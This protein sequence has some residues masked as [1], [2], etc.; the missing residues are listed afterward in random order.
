[1]KPYD[2]DTPKA[3]TRLLQLRD[4]HRPRSGL[5]DPTIGAPDPKKKRKRKRGPV[6]EEAE[7]VDGNAGVANEDGSGEPTAGG[8]NNTADT[9]TEVVTQR[10]QTEPEG[11]RAPAP[12]TLRIQP[13]ERLAD[14]AARVDRALPLGRRAGAASKSSSRPGVAGPSE[15]LTRHAKRLRKMQAAWREDE[16][17]LREKEE[18]E[19]EEAEGEW[20]ERVA[21]M[22][23][24]DAAA[25]VDGFRGGRGAGAA[26][27]AAAASGKA[28]KKKKRQGGGGGGGEDDPWAV[29]KGRRDEVRGLHDV[30]KEPPRFEKKPRRILGAKVVDVPRAA[31]SLSR[32]EALGETRLEIIQ[33]YRQMM[34]AKRGQF[35]Q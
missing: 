6:R 22:G 29:L 27:L 17:R 10:Q 25:L 26:A 4:G 5:D 33:R 19:R 7:G 3:F 35:A 13:G 12:E 14:F 30:A 20:D 31:G 15:P 32:R 8:D 21:E 23:G 18:D 24:G 2:R 28:G 16:A 1:L 9:A 11:P 34:A